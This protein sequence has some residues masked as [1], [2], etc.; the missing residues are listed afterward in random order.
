MKRI[1]LTSLLIALA[2]LLPFASRSQQKYF[3]ADGG[4]FDPKVPTPESFLGYDIGTFYTR[5]DQLIAYLKELARVSDRVHLEVIGKTY[6][7]REQVILTITSPENYRNI[8]SIR[9]AHLA[10]A[11]PAKPALTASAPVVVL[12]GYSV[13][14][15]ETSSGEAGIL[16][17]YYLAASQSEET[18]KWLSESVVLLDPSLNPDGRD[19]AANWHNSYHSEPYSSDPLDKEHVEGWPNG[20][21]NHY[22][23]NL[24]RDWLSATQIESQNRLKFF[25]RW[26]PNVHIDFHEMGANSTYYFE[27][28]PKRT[29]SPIV[30]QASYDFNTTLARYHADAL[31]KI[32]SLYF[33]KE[34]FDNLSPIYGSTYPDFFGAVGVTFEQASSRGLLTE[35]ETGLLSFAFTI[36][37][38][39]LTGLATVRGAVAEKTGLFKL[40]KEFFQSA[41]TQGK[42]YPVKQW[43]FGDAKDQSLTNHFLDLLLQHQVEVYEIGDRVVTAGKTFDKGKAYVVPADQPNFRIVHSIFEETAPLADSQFYDNTS[44]SLIHAYGLQ[45]AKQT[46]AGNRGNRVTTVPQRSGSVTGA[47]SGVGYVVSWSEYDASKL[48]QLLLDKDIVV[49]SAH[50]PFTIKKDNGQ[51]AFSYGSLVIPTASQRIAPDSLYRLL[52]TA[53][54]L[55]KVD[56]V[57]VSTGFSLEGIDLGS[58]NIKAVRKPAIAVIFGTGVNYEEAGQ[59]WF[60]LNQQVGVA[61]T[62]LDIG[63][64]PRAGISRYNTII[65]PSGSYNTL[66]KATVAKLKSWVADG[67]T[68]ILFKN[69]ID[70]A[71]QQEILKERLAVDSSE[72]KLTERLDY[73]SQ[74]ATEAARRINGGVFSADIDISHPI[75]FGLSNRKIFFTKNSQT[76]L[77]SSRNKY[78]TVAKYDAA[79]YVGGYVSKKNIGRINN[80]AAIL[81]SQEGS[82]KIISFADDPTYRSY[83]HGTDRLLLNAIYFGNQIQLRSGFI[84]AAEEEE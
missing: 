69:A 25:H 17:A 81:V 62:K 37:N 54:A 41:L 32:G 49:K 36:R 11:D 76:I 61:P 74:E 66:D 39:F 71:I 53:A 50:R 70:W 40:Q 55:A 21:S 28:S 1:Q 80:T 8:E 31:D 84:G 44:W 14:G 60:L 29:Q 46:A 10:Q 73:A 13:H 67:G 30:P 52:K 22:L 59:V 68:L 2:L 82:G 45:Y 38:Q 15:N 7:Q 20:R 34:Q 58:N 83:W 64:L 12:L 19:R 72:G 27:P 4:P 6:E 57:P 18:K 23:A 51:L 77:L 16:T 47:Q 26:Y 3:F 33:T 63:T 78:A 56:I 65:L 43:V 42:A 79:S 48:L 75:A 9:T 5:H 35:T 24:N